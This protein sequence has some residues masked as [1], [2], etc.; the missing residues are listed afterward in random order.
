MLYSP[1]GMF[2]SHYEFDCTSNAQDIHK[3]SV[4]CEES[5]CFSTTIKKC[6]NGQETF[7]WWVSLWIENVLKN[8]QTYSSTAFPGL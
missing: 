6:N 8:C 1:D 5:P 7:A 4:E 3:Q 2:L